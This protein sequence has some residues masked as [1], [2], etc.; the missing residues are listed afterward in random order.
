MVD[1][2]PVCMVIIVSSVVARVVIG[3]H[4]PELGADRVRDASILIGCS[5]P[6]LIGS[7]HGSCVPV[8]SDTS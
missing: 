7:L 1:P 5:S 4:C 2:L 6:C 3:V 8:L